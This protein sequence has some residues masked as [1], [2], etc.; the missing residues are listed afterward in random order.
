MCILLTVWQQ[1]EISDRQD[2]SLSSASEK[3]S[4]Y[5]LDAIRAGHTHHPHH[6]GTSQGLSAQEGA[7]TAKSTA[8]VEIRGE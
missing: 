5:T 6:H 8:E 2:E 4:T 7:A 3:I 1:M